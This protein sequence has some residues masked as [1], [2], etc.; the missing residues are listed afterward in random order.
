MFLLFVTGIIQMS[1]IAHRSVSFSPTVWQILLSDVGQREGM[2]AGN[3]KRPF[4]SQVLRMCLNFV[5]GITTRF[6]VWY[7]WVKNHCLSMMNTFL[8]RFFNKKLTC[9]FLL[10]MELRKSRFIQEVSVIQKPKDTPGSLQYSYCTI[11]FEHTDYQWYRKTSF[12]CVFFSLTHQFK[13]SWSSP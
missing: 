12:W 1:M 13:Q 4:Y 2:M 6:R 7:I 11:F 3:K 9:D 8:G 10:L 5:I